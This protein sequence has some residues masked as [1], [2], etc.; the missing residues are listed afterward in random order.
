MNE[1]VFTF[2]LYLKTSLYVCA[3]YMYVLL[4]WLQIYQFCK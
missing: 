3:L 2:D 4:R 1:L